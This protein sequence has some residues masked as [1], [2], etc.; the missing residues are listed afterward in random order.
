MRK[1]VM[2]ALGISLL[3]VP[4][5]AAELKTE[6]QKTFYAVGGVIAN[7]LSVFGLSPQE[8][9]LVQ[10][11]VADGVAGKMQV[12]ME[13][14]QPKIQQLALARRDAQGKKL[15]AEGKEFIAKAAKEKGAVKGASGVIYQPLKEGTG[16][17]PAATDKVKVHY[18][19]TL[20]DGKEFDS[21]YQAGQ[22]AEFQLDKVIPCWTE[23]VQQMRVGGKAKLV[24]PPETAY[25]ERGAGIIPPNATLVF[26]VELL[27]VV[28]EP[29]N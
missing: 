2:A 1:A 12:N 25:A 15:A 21:S 3:A 29:K 8:L 26:E 9:E 22:P 11:G 17:K 18:R 4:A 24:C 28:K 19:G 23:G 6:E 10:Q 14:Y 7:Q 16:A 13:E 27:D 20:T 5:L